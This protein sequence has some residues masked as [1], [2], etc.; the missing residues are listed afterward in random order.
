MSP[1][2]KRAK[3]GEDERSGGMANDNAAGPAL[4]PAHAPGDQATSRKFASVRIDAR[5]PGVK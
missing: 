5:Q 2:R 4:V 1:L 3:N